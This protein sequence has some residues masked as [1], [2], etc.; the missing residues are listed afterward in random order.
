MTGRD[1]SYEEAVYGWTGYYTGID[2]RKL[3]YIEDMRQRGF[4]TFLLSNTNPFMMSWA[5]S[6]EFTGRG[7]PLSHYFD[8]MYLSYQCR[9]AKPSPAFYEFLL[10][11]AGISAIE[12][13]FTDDGLVNVIAAGKRGFHT[14]NPANGE[15]WRPM[16]D[17][18]IGK[19]NGT[20]NA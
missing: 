17:E 19:E 12:S 14:L 5:E 4:K 3:D 10:K 11:D 9:M 8:K 6:P 15:D 7:Y 16:I 2:L 20:G 18:I 1:I 13:I